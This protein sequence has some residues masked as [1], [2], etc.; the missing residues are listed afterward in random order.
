ML[1]LELMYIVGCAGSGWAGG[2]PDCQRVDRRASGRKGYVDAQIPIC[3][4][5]MTKVSKKHKFIIGSLTFHITRNVQV[6]IFCS[7]IN[8]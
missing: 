3:T 7:N 8:T 1:D 2:M 6:L 5:Q 4:A